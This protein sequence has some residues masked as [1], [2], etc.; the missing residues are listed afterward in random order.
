[1]IVIDYFG[2]EEDTIDMKAQEKEESDELKMK[3]FKALQKMWAEQDQL[4]LQLVEE[5]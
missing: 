4:Q 3:R 2:D 1:M 5:S